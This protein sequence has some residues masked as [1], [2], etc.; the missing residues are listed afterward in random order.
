MSEISN[1]FGPFAYLVTAVI[2]FFMVRTLRQVDVNQR[3]LWHHMDEH[4]KRLSQLE[5]KHQ[6][7]MEQG[8]HGR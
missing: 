5:G 4:E 7:V 3:E 6:A 8:G 1:Q 2:G